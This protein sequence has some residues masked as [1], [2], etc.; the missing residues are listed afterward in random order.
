[1]SKELK[2][3]CKEVIKML[4]DGY[5]NG[6]TDLQIAKAFNTLKKLD[7]AKMDWHTRNQAYTELGSVYAGM[8]GDKINFSILSLAAL[9]DTS[10][11]KQHEDKTLSRSLQKE[12]TDEVIKAID[13]WDIRCWSSLRDVFPKAFPKNVQG[14]E[15]GE[16]GWE[17]Y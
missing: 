16:N 5:A 8:V 3:E 13:N 6:M 7:N 9:L 12:I 17:L 14:M 15:L 4:L 2:K 11:K 1:M 10:Y